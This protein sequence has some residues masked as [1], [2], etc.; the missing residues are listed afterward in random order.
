MTILFLDYDG[1]LHPDPCSD[2]LRLFEHAPRLAD[3]LRPFA[4]VD[5]V[6]STAWRTHVD[7][8]Q[9]AAHLPPTLRARVVGITPCFHRIS[10]PPARVP[11]RRQAE[12]L[13]WIE[14]ERPGA[15]WL[16]LDDRAS[17]FE[18]YCDRLITTPSPTGLDDAALNRLRFVLMRMALRPSPAAPLLSAA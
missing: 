1:V 9:L 12:C 14:S 2:R 4:D 13:H 7:P 18:P 5:I 3:A 8:V 11:Y 16:A 15:E 10:C 6:L 17:G